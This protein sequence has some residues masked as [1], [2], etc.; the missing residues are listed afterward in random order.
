MKD[1]QKGTE[2]TLGGGTNLPVKYRRFDI[3]PF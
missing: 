2:P 3:T 1:A